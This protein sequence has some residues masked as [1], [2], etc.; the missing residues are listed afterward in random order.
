MIALYATL[1]IPL[2]ATFVF[3]VIGHWK[4]AGTLNMLVCAATFATSLQLAV[5][6]FTNGAMITPGKMFYIDPFNV[7]LILVRPGRFNHLN[8]QPSL[9]GARIENRAGG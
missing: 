4:H 8:F 6:I 1:L 9:H 3:G 7:Y 5:N 2:V